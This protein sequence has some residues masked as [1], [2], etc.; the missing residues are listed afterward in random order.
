MV[1]VSLRNINGKQWSTE[2]RIYCVKLY[3]KSHSYT[4]VQ[5]IFSGQNPLS[6]VGS[7]SLNRKGLLRTSTR[8]QRTQNKDPGGDEKHLKDNL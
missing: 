8:N 7:R 5:K 6:L 2:K 4:A 1:D 3:Y